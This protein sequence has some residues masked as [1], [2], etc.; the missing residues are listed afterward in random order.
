MS[1]HTPSGEYYYSP[2]VM[3]A[4]GQNGGYFEIPPKSSSANTTPR[5]VSPLFEKRPSRHELPKSPRP[6]DGVSRSDRSSRSSQ[7]DGERRGERQS[8]KAH[9]SSS[10]EEHRKSRHQRK[11]SENHL[12]PEE[13]SSHH[14]SSSRSN[15]SSLEVKPQSRYTMPLASPL[16][17]PSRS[18]F[19]ERNRTDTYPPIRH[20]RLSSRPVSPG[21]DLPESPNSTPRLV[22]EIVGSR[23]PSP[24]PGHDFEYVGP[25]T[26]P[27]PSRNGAVSPGG[28]RRPPS[29]RPPQSSQAW[30]PPSFQPSLPE[31][32]VGTYRRYSQDMENGA[33]PPLPRCPRDKFVTGHNDWYTLPGCPTF[34]VCP[35]CFN[36]IIAPTPHRYMFVPAPPRPLNTEVLCDFGSSPWHRIAWLMMRKERLKDVSLIYQI[37]EIENNCQPCTS[38]HEGLR[39]WYSII[40][41][42]T[43]QPVRNF[44]ICHRC[45]KCIEAILPILRGIFVRV[46]HNSPRICDMRFDSKRFVHYFDA[47]ETTSDEAIHTR[48]PPNMTAI[49]EVAKR[50]AAFDD[51]PR[52]QE[53]YNSPWHII[54]Q[55]PELTVCPECYDEMIKPLARKGKAIPNMFGRNPIILERGTCQLYSERMRRKFTEKVEM[56]DYL[57]LAAVVRERRMR[58]DTYRQGL[59][60]PRVLGGDPM[61]QER[62]LRL[63]EE[64]KRYE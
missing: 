57:G 55:L 51:C 64:W 61:A 23:R 54:T 21:S 12:R 37:A 26:L 58:E 36:S 43:R 18:C 2:D 32:P 45:V 35:S 47:L 9:H 8:S 17:T 10:D 53:I 56:D 19:D 44:D 40:D 4:K 13:T 15:R 46:E 22:P 63:I 14:R 27:I 24:I 6:L 16:G 5:P 39:Q 62:M 38:K 34:D 42:T 31:P 28:T 29:E 41:P 30:Q 1:P 3:S 48:G 11:P 50:F 60:Q 52:D 33:I 20:R 59:S 7:F 49:V 25:S